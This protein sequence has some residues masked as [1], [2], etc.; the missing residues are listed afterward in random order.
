[1]L[2]P[3]V[4][5]MP[6]VE[7]LEQM[8]GYARYM[9]DLLIKKKTVSYEPLDNLHHC[10]AIATRSLVQKKA[11]PG[12][13][14]ILGL[15]DPMLTNMRLLMADRSVKRSVRILSDVFIKV[16]SFTFPAD[17]VILDFDV[18]FKV[19]IILGRLFL[20]IWRVL[21]NLEFN[22]LKFRLNVKRLALMCD[23][24]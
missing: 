16:A 17:F 23:N 10:S 15:R 24:L 12:S 4:V 13:F 6:L 5:N 22:K 14:T 18:D 21:I 8:P 1:M 7:A 11:E 3:L 20:A 9:K 2:K 19:P